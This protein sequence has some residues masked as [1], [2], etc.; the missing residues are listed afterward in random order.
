M[1]FWESFQLGLREIWA[2]KFRSLLTMLGIILGVSSLVAMSALVKGMER[3]A[4]EALIAVGGLQ[5]IRVEPAEVPA[6][7]QH[8]RDQAVGVTMKDVQALR[9]SAPLVTDLSPEMRLPNA[10]LT[11]N[12]KHFR[13]FICAGVW[14]IALPMSEHVLAQ[15]RM[16][17]EIDDEQAR[18]VCVIGTATRDELFGSPEELGHEVIPIG[19]T[20]LIN[21]QPFTIIGLFQH[22]ESE[23]QRKERE[24]AQLE[25]KRAP[26]GPTR[27]RGGGGGGRRGGNFV[28]WLKNASVFLPLNT[29]WIKFRSGLAASPDPRLSTLELK[30]A[31]VERMNVALQQIRNVLMSTHQGIEDFSFRTQEE[32]AE[33]INTFIRNARLSGGIIAGISLLVGGIGIMNIMLASISGRIREIGIRKAVGAGTGDIFFQILVESVA[34]AILGGLVGLAASYG[35]VRIISQLS[36]TENTPVITVTA[37]VLAFGSSVG[38]GILAGL[39]PAFKAARLDPIEALRY[40]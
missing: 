23:Q 5:K 14:P 37:M 13:P 28:F 36:P 1:N 15:G 8:L 39:F 7:Q 31:D 12:G 38:I 29:V 10:T 11:A 33:N 20:I 24:L 30:I 34:I 32:W 9:H 2:H 40:E 26:T 35:L 16:F 17:N 21:R 25:P 4:K 19:E 27:S 3:G 22:Y 18:S 6:E